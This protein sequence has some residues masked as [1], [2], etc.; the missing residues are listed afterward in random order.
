MT[1]GESAYYSVAA[2]IRG[3]SAPVGK[4]NTGQVGC[5]SCQKMEVNKLDVDFVIYMRV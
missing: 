3:F 4:R 2:V 1:I 5:K